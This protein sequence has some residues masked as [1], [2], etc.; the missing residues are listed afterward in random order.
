MKKRALTFILSI[1]L[2]ISANPLI[3]F[4]DKQNSIP[5]TDLSGFEK[6]NNYIIYTSVYNNYITGTNPPYNT[7]FSPLT[8]LNR[9]MLVTILYR[10]DGSPYDTHNPYKH[11]PFT[12]VKNTKLYFYNAICWALDEGITDQIIFNPFKN[13]TREESV[14][15][16]FRY[17]MHK[18]YINNDDYKKISLNKFADFTAVRKWAYEAF[19]WANYN[20][21]ITGTEQGCL[22]PQGFTKRIHAAKIFAVFGNACKIGTLITPPYTPIPHSMLIAN[23]QNPA[24]NKQTIL[25]TQGKALNIANNEW[26]TY[27]G[28]DI[29]SSEMLYIPYGSAVKTD[30]N[31]LKSLGYKSFDFRFYQYSKEGK[32]LGEIDK[33]YLCP[34]DNTDDDMKPTNFVVT[35]KNGIYVRIRWVKWEN[36]FTNKTGEEADSCFEVYSLTDINAEIF[37]NST[38]TKCW[39]NESVY[40][41][42]P[43][44]CIFFNPNDDLYYAFYASQTAHTNYDGKILFRTSTDLINWSDSTAVWDSN[45]NNFP[46]A[47]DG[48]LICANGDFL[49]S[50]MCDNLIGANKYTKTR[51]LRSTDNGLTWSVQNFILDNKDV[52]GIYRLNRARILEDGRIFAGYIDSEKKEKAGICF[53]EDNGLTWTSADFSSKYSLSDNNEYDFTLLNNGNILCIQRAKDVGISAAISTDNGKSFI[54]ETSLAFISNKQMVNCPFIRYDK[55]NDRLTIY[56]IDRF[57]TG[58]LVGIYTSG[59][60]ITDFLI[61]QAEFKGFQANVCALG[62]NYNAD[63]GYPHII[64]A[65]DGSIKCFY[66]STDNGKAGTAAWYCISTI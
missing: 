33:N 14:T 55:E 22:D 29:I 42:W 18:N 28:S 64:E 56:E 6:Y 26:I 37:D 51:F 23:N 20:E 10:M 49:I 31:K 45:I 65:P 32:Y 50:M 38:I 2:I 30:T 39:N 21:I 3:S 46:A 7:T 1:I 16:L 27:S 9:A 58:A 25:F 34:E 17:A 11:S 57:R 4:A 12:D 52:T 62:Q 13:V 47:I 8:S 60:N 5:F 19:Q 43:N 44:K 36:E 54:N 40:E 59:N 48:A 41:A 63:M 66:Y 61:N 35:D 53:S 24:E 15:F